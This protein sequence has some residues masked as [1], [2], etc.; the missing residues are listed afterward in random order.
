MTST[1]RFISN[2]RNLLSVAVIEASSVKPSKTIRTLE[3]SR[4]GNGVVRLDGEYTGS[5]GTT[6]DV[7]IVEGGGTPTASIPMFLGVGSGAMEVLSVSSLASQEQYIFSL[8]DLGIK[9]EIAGLDIK[10]VRVTSKVSG[11][12]GNSIRF[13][14]T[15]ALTKTALPFALL[16]DWPAS[17]AFKTGAQWDFGASP[18]SASGT[19]PETVRRVSFGED[20]AV[21]RIY[22]QYKEG[23]WQF[24]TSPVL[25]RD[26]AKG[27]HVFE[28]SG[29]YTVTVSDGVDT[30]TYTDLVTFYDLLDALA[31]SDLVTVAGLVS[32]G[33]APGEQAVVDVPLRTSA[34]LRS[35]N[36][37]TIKVGSVG[38]PSTA[39]TQKV[40]ASC[41]NAAIIGGESWSVKGTVS[42]DLPNATTGVAFASGA[43][44][45]TILPASSGAIPTGD[46]SFTYEPAS[47]EDTEGV[48]SVCLKPLKM[49]LNV[50]PST[51]TFVYKRRPPAECSC[52]T[53]PAISLS[54]ECLGLYEGGYMALDA[55]YQDRLAALYEWQADFIASNAILQAQNAEYGRVLAE[56]VDIAIAKGVTSI[57]AEALAEIYASGPARAV[58]DTYLGA[59]QAE[60][61]EYEGI[62]SVANGAGREA[63]TW[64]AEI[65]LLPGAYVRPTVPNGRL[66]LVLQ[67][68]VT[69]IT[70]PD[71]DSITSPAT[72]GTAQYEVLSPY[73]TAS[74]AITAGASVEPGNGRRYIA[75][76]GGTTGATEPYWPASGGL[77]DGTVDWAPVTGSVSGRKLIDSETS[78]LVSGG[79]VTAAARPGS[80][81][82]TPATV[83][84]MVISND[85]STTWING[86]NQG[87]ERQVI[88]TSGGSS[89]V[90]HRVFGTSQAI[91][92][93]NARSAAARLAELHGSV[94]TTRGTA[95]ERSPIERQTITTRLETEPYLDKIRAQMD[96]VRTLAGIVP[97]SDASSDAGACW[98]DYP[99]ETHWWIDPEGV[100]LPAFTN[101][102][103]VSSKRD[104]ETG[105]PY[106]TK[107]FGFGLVVACPD[108]LKVDDR[109]I[110]RINKVDTVRPFKE[111]DAFEFETVAAAPAFLGGGVDGTDEHTW[112]VKGSLTGAKPDYVVP[113][114]SPSS[115]YVVGGTTI[116]INNGGIPFELGDSFSVSVEANQYRW[117]K[118]AGVWSVI[119]DIP[120]SGT[121]GISDGLSIKFYPGI[122]PSFL[123]EDL[124]SFGV[125]QPNSPIHVINPDMTKWK[126]VGPT[127]SLNVVLPTETEFDALALA[128]YAL[129]SGASVQF[130]HSLDGVIWSDFIPVTLGSSVS[131]TLVEE[132]TAKYLNVVVSGA[133]DGSLGWLW[134]GTAM[135]TEFSATNCKRRRAYSV[136]RGNGPN[137]SGLYLGSGDGWDLTWEHF[138]TADDVDNLVGVFNHSIVTG[139]PLILVPNVEHL[140]DSSLVSV[141]DD[142]FEITD[143]HEYQPDLAS[144]RLLSMNVVLSP[145]IR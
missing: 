93:A 20:P 89:G 126:W 40:I 78:E 11:A 70:E 49:G 21:Y 62:V 96:Y 69:D 66:Y 103:Y 54:M 99:E 82:K 46:I 72:D 68:G 119:S 141:S 90:K 61:L 60:L 145:V 63:V 34:W 118:G 135:A 79:N 67:E 128:K 127:G 42:G 122:A 58:W 117:R 8:A 18:L 87:Y 25:E 83:E 6:I 114:T 48:P 98:R 39:P 84:I 140:G 138:L 45:F 111:G 106:S 30:E 97:K 33:Y 116:K 65:T 15:P 92:D 10:A 142:S 50:T 113:T 131:V 2:D 91:A 36:L 121:V 32:K 3:V 47:R 105:K 88:V 120:T 85:P 35:S 132:V 104:A 9:T 44:N 14:V 115:P 81:V 23:D 74:A 27:S 137:A 13:T 51:H 101:K 133:E 28:V 37:G 53:M 4:E 5:V 43:I 130:R 144:D 73:W 1:Q 17:T 55:E 136:S 77:S 38:V 124:F 64:T 12:A 19:I 56:P 139:H 125:I 129:P 102:A 52:K 109:I 16:E 108:R 76:S 71:W 24:G 26:I 57:L 95:A 29:G 80:S 75:A 123:D 100:Y 31:D 107:E 94:S 86:V 110:V 41:V 59:V 7:Q 134:V 143:F 22:R 112:K